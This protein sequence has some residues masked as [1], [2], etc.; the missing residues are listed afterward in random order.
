MDLFVALELGSL[1]I[2]ELLARFI[3]LTLFLEAPGQAEKY[4]VAAGACVGIVFFI[5]RSYGLYNRGMPGLGGVMPGRIVLALSFAFMALISIAYI[6]KTSSDYSRGW[7]LLWFGLSCVFVLGMRYSY[8]PVYQWLVGAGFVARR[9]ALVA[10]LDDCQRL[11]TDLVAAKEIEIVGMFDPAAG[12][13]EID[14]LIRVGQQGLVD[15]IVV[16]A[17]GLPRAELGELLHRLEIL[18][19]DIRLSIEQ[20]PRDMEVQDVQRVGAVSLL[21][22]TRK[23]VCD[24]GHVAKAI[25]DYGIAA[26]ALVILSPVMLLIALAIKLDSAGPV[27]FRQQR[28]GYNHRIIRVFKFRT[29]YE[30]EDGGQVTQA[31]RNDARVTR[32]GRFLR[33]TSLDEL[34]QLLNVLLGEMSLVGPRPHAISHNYHYQQLLSEYANRHR[35]KPGITGL[36]QI[37][38]FRGPTEDPELMHQRVRYDLEYIKNWSFWLDIEIMFKTVFAVINR[39][40]AF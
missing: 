25:E 33:R 16:S 19:V 2:A 32:V 38:G 23:P 17:A 11:R 29:M 37:K 8:L 30:A 13:P 26:I 5:F 34:P 7:F 40:N 18:P 28:H 31:V 20:L 4:F 3:Y 15:G 24:W 12:R 6:S 1:L 27:F 36:A 35:M 22:V 10:N 39:R 21:Q 9:I 14:E